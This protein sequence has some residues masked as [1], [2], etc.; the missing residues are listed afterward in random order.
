[1]HNHVILTGRITADPE[2]R[3]TPAGK[4]NCS[5]DLAVQRSQDRDKTDFIEIM[6]WGQNAVFV[7]KYLK[8]GNLVDLSGSIRTRKWTDKNGTIRYKTF[9]YLENIYFAPTNNRPDR[10]DN[11][12]QMNDFDEIT[13]TDDL[14]F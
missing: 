10:K 5:F 9:V 2:L 6:A 14:P 7:T 1:M 3:Q 4:Y 13:D 11:V 12:T 8:K